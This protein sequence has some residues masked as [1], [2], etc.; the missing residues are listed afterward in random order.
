M[1]LHTTDQKALLREC[2]GTSSFNKITDNFTHTNERESAGGIKI[3]PTAVTNSRNTN[4][5]KEF[6]SERKTVNAN[7]SKMPRSSVF[8]RTNVPPLFLVQHRTECDHNTRARATK[9]VPK[10]HCS[11]IDIHFFC[12]RNGPKEDRYLHL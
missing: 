7:A 1:L 6:G 8:Q 5:R 12:R 4:S 11:T 2:L 3:T 10:R 9:G